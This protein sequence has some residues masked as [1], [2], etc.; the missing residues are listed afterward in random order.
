MENE[1]PPTQTKSGLSSKTVTIIVIVVV[2]AAAFGVWTI[3]NWQAQTT[4]HVSK[5]YGEVGMT[6]LPSE[7]KPIAPAPA[8][9]Q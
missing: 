4:G 1:I 6:I 7:S 5:N 3:L 8:S 9:G 2:L